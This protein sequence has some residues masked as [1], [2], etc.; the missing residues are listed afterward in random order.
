MRRGGASRMPAVLVAATRFPTHETQSAVGGARLRAPAS[1][2][3]NASRRA[4]PAEPLG[5]RRLHHGGDSEVNVPNSKRS[6]RSR[7]A[8]AGAS[9]VEAVVL[10]VFIGLGLIA[11]VR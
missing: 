2:A 3:C 8:C 11:G 7:A 4:A 6:R 1:C 9:Y 5:A 10:V